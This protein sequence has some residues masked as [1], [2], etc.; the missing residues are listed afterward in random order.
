MKK[1]IMATAVSMLALS[2][3]V[4]SATTIRI[5]H[6]AN[7]NYHLHRALEK[8]KE[9][10]EAKSDGKFEVQIFANSQMGP[11]REMIEGVQSGMLQMAVSPSSFYSSWDPSFDVVEL[12]FI[13]PSKQ[14]ALDTVHSPMGDKM[15]AKLNNMNLQGLGWME[16]G[17][18]HVTNNS[19]PINSPED[20][21]GL[22]IRTMKVPAHVKTFN[23]LN[24]SA[25]PMNF[26]E[27][28]SG[29]QQGVVDGQENPIAHIY[30]QRFYEVQ[31]YVSLTGHVIT[32]YI[33]VMNLEFWHGLSADDQKLIKESMRAA[34]IY[35][36]ELVSAEEGQQIEEFKK[37]G[38]QVNALSEEQLQKFIDA[39][40]PVR[41][42]YKEKLGADVYDA[43]MKTI[44]EVTSKS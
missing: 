30:A 16:N 19:R 36:Q 2:T 15:L 18:R 26:G 5:G 12:P 23:S 32:F 4:M 8:F 34:E 21:K 24:A 38:T 39:T 31:D 42:E 17:V 40:E 6:G 1:L 22:K 13:Y 11:D 27:V 25:T 37:Q 44:K 33:P 10:V 35:Q 29:L 14:A 20:L 43:W 41:E 28:Y 7:E 9:D 3:S